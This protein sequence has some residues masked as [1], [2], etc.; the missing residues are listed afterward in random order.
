MRDNP[1]MESFYEENAPQLSGQTPATTGGGGGGRTDAMATL[2]RPLTLDLNGKDLHPAKRLRF[3]N[4]NN[5]TS[6]ISTPDLQMLKM[7]SP[8]LEK[9]IMNGNP[10]AT[11]TPSQN[12]PQK[13]VSLHYWL[14]PCLCRRSYRLSRSVLS[15][16]SSV[17]SPFPPYLFRSVL[18]CPVANNNLSGN[19]RITDCRILSSPNWAHTQSY[20]KEVPNGSTSAR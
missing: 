13:E 7:L 20:Q 19:K 17:L 3:N 6:V 8:E 1:N 15:P 9:I 4:N 18:P 5:T 2:K 10:L 12:Y 11:P 16:Q 14:C